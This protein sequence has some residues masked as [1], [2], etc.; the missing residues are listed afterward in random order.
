M[1]ALLERLDPQRQDVDQL[2]D[3]FKLLR[4]ARPLDHMDAGAKVRTLCQLLKGNP[5]HAGALRAYVLGLLAGRRHTSL[6]TDIGVL[7]NDGFF[8]ELKRRIAYR[9]LPPALGDDYLSDALDQILYLDTDYLW[10]AAVPAADWLA[11]FDVLAGAAPAA[12]PAG[13]DR[14]E[15]PGTA[16]MLPG[17]LDAIRTL[18]YRLCA[19]GLEPALARFHSE[20]ETFASPFVMQN[21]EVNA[22]LD[23][24]ARL[25]DGAAGD[26]DGVDDAR[27]LLVMLDQC[28]AVVG[29]IRRKALTQ[30]TSIALTYLLVALTQSADRLRK[31]LF[32]VDTTGE[33]PSAPTL[34][35]AALAS[36]AAPGADEAVSPRRAAAL[37]LALE[38]IAAHGKRY[39]VRGLFA[40]NIDLLAR[41]VTE[42]A[43]RTGEHYIAEDRREMRAMLRS[44]AGAGLVIG[45]MALCKLLLS[46]LRAAPLVEAFLF[47]INYSLGFMFIHVLHFTVATKQPAMTAARIAAGLHSQDGRNIDLDSMAELIN[48]V[49]R[50]QLTAVL[51]NLATALP[52]AWLIALAWRAATGRHLV[53]PEK[54]LHLLHDID[55][56]GSLALFYAAIAGACLFVSGLISGYYDNAALYTRWAQRVAQLRGLGRLLGQRRLKRLGLYMENNLGGLMGNFYFGILL[57]TLGTLGYLLGLPLDIRH[58]TFSAANFATAA[59]GLD[60]QIGWQLA[61]R[62]LGGVLAIGAVN[63]LVSFGLALWVALRAR[64]VRFKRGVA[65]L[66]ALGRRFLQAPLT[67]FI[68]PPARPAEAATQRGSG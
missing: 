9:M 24:Y 48:K 29:K 25:L 16:V 27:H 35:L 26:V 34:D 58:V 41:N 3:L 22:Y 51:G 6:Y 44:S 14:P 49:L 45:F 54:A 13:Q 4:P 18:S 39:K 65:L 2:I 56:F 17:M 33:L 38:L 62:S 8:T 43:S 10:I 37:A 1:L 47:S 7:S 12:P 28:D 20:I 57:G 53:T 52:T 30:G 63:L 64:Q 36:E 40:D 67:F 50:T 5:A 60:H 31:L 11:L 55:P 61:A 42:N 15:P 66:R 23:G 59:V 19:I 46:Y 21:V 68:G 32:L